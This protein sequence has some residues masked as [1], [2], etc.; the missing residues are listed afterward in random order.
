MT[1]KTL[2]VDIK[3]NALD[4]GPGIRT[5]LFFKGCPLSCVWCQNPEAKSPFKE[6]SFNKD[7]C[8]ECGTCLKVCNQDA[9]DF[10][11]KYRIDRS[12]CNLCGK[13]IEVC[14]NYALEFVGQ[15]YSIKEL[16]EII[17]K[18]K[19]FY[20]NSGGG[21][22]FSGGE[23]LYHIDYI[24]ELVKELKKEDIHVCLETSGYYNRDKFYEFILPYIDLIYFDLKIYNPKLHARYCKVSNESILENFED[25]I[26][27]KSIEILPRIPLIPNITDTDE[28]LSNLA[29]Y[30]KTFKIKKIGL[31][32]YNPLWLSKPEKIGIKPSYDYTAWLDN[33][34]KE[35]IKSIFS[36]FEF[37]DL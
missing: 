28:N 13:C 5:L 2:L 18:D 14:P 11:N 3:R 22:T 27:N 34:D 17:L 23:P 32:P 20:K 19:I 8:S 31:L 36:D 25:I 26:K 12:L 6:I 16:L 35:R 33:K 29:N 37:N 9:I 21:V 10:S 24:N 4:D 15:E 1:D 30:L 7:S